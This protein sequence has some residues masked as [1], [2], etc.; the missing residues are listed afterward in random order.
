MKLIRIRRL[1][2]VIAAAGCLAIP[3]TAQADYTLPDTFRTDAA[4]LPGARTGDLSQSAYTYGG[5]G[6]NPADHPGMS[7]ATDYQQPATI[8][9]VRPERT[10]V[11]DV[12]EALPLILSSA[13]LMLVIAGVGIMLVRGGALRPRRSN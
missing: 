4:Q 1:T 7:R 8:E 3:A 12:D 10:I 13:A 5:H 11:R 2:L 9:V 6:D